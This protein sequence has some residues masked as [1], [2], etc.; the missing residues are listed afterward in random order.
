MTGANTPAAGT[1]GRITARDRLWKDAAATLTP[2]KS[3]ARVEDKA[4]Q[5]VGSVTLVG[6]VLAGLGLIAPAG[7]LLPPVARALAVSAVCVAVG[8][9]VLAMGS[10]LL[11]FNASLA[12]GDLLEVERWFRRQFRR[13]YLVVAAGALLLLAVM[14]AAAAAITT[15]LASSSADPLVVLQVGRTGGDVQMG[16][17]AEISGLAPGRWM[18]VEITGVGPG[19]RTMI[20]SA[21]AHASGTATTSVTVPA[22]SVREYETVELLITVPGRRCTASLPLGKGPSGTEA[23]AVMC[24]RG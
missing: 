20:A 16:M 21:V 14:I 7:F 12:P 2:D 10:V 24:R 3:L 9:V 23:D 11:R 1:G 13:A 22:Y 4:K 5:V 6:T 19:G 8:A 17:R 15:L 18:R